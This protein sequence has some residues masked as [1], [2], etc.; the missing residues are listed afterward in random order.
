M[1]D[2]PPI[3]A[4]VAHSGAMCLLD[5]V[6]SW[7]AD[8][9]VCQ[10]TSHARSDNPLRHHGRLAVH[11]GVEY[12]AQ[13]MAA[14]AA[15]TGGAAGP[16]PGYL[17]VVSGLRWSVDRLDDIPGPLSVTA[18][19]IARLP[20]GQCYGFTLDAHAA[21]LLDGEAIVVLA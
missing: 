7:D 16:R 8:R 11:T 9:I 18:W 2:A 10:A 3:Q 5:R 13:A 4:L 20:D 12:A 21:R 17:A 15:L 14:H 19:R 1:T 6:L